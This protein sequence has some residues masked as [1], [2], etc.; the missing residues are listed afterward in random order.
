MSLTK[1]Q[2]LV[3]ETLLPSTPDEKLKPGIEDVAFGNFYKNFEQ[4]SIWQFRFTFK[5][6][7]FIAIWIAPLLRRKIPPISLYDAPERTEILYALYKAP[8]NLFRQLMIMLKLVSS[9][10][11]APDSRVREAL[12]YPYKESFAKLEG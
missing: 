10:A 4:T 5:L 8:I 1:R 2:K 9:L 7:L 6:A 12:G 3:L 11:Y